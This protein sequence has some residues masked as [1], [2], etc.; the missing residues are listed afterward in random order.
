MMSLLGLLASF[1]L[2]YRYLPI[3]L[4]MVSTSTYFTFF[5]V[6][7]IIVNINEAN[8]FTRSEEVVGVEPSK[9]EILISKFTTDLSIR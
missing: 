2:E 7:R 5:D 6:A 3:S 9:D 1:T 8:V 4:P